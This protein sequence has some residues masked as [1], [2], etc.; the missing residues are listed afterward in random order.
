MRTLRQHKHARPRAAHVVALLL[1]LVV[2]PACTD[3]AAPG[4][5]L[6]A[7]PP[8]VEEVDTEPQAIPAPLSERVA[9]AA[10]AISDNSPRFRAAYKYLSILRAGH[11][12]ILCRKAHDRKITIA[13]AKRLTED[14]RKR[15]LR[16]CLDTVLDPQLGDLAYEKVPGSRF[17]H[18][19][20]VAE[21]VYNLATDANLRLEAAQLWN[22]REN[23]RYD[24]E[25]AGWYRVLKPPPD[26]TLVRPA[27][28]PVRPVRRTLPRW[29][30]HYTPPSD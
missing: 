23:T 15:W 22:E 30:L 5:S 18:S 3:R 6:A 10:A 2:V 1:G 7:T 14:D 16:E 12:V 29:D 21:A 17:S 24:E 25:L 11:F 8:T 27:R 28:R 26:T 20:T 4:P 13:L 19:I 9:E